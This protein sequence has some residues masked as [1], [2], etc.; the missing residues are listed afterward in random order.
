MSWVLAGGAEA[1][2]CC[3]SV[4]VGVGADE[5]AD[6]ASGT[7]MEAVEAETRGGATTLDFFL[8][9]SDSTPSSAP[10]RAAAPAMAAGT[11][12]EGL[13]GMLGGGSIFTVPDGGM[14][15][16]VLAPG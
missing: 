9:S 2:S 5:E 11:T 14:T 15:I 8:A 4:D 12:E 10:A 6:L 1:S 3:E 13:A 7:M 16:E